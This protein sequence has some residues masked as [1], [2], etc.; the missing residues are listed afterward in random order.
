MHTL[1]LFSALCL[2]AAGGGIGTTPPPPPNPSFANTVLV[3]GAATLPNGSYSLVFSLI[4]NFGAQFFS[5]TIFQE[6]QQVTVTGSRFSTRLGSNTGGG[7]PSSLLAGRA[8]LGVSWALATSPTVS[9]G[10]LSLPGL[11]TALTLAPQATVAGRSSVTPALTVSGSSKG[12]V[13]TSSSTSGRGLIGDATSTLGL[14]IG[15][16]G[17][18]AA[19]AGAGG[20]FLNSGAGGDVLHARNADGASPVFRVT[21]SGDV[22]SAG[23]LVPQ[24]GPNGPRGDPG[25]PAAKGPTG[26]K[27]PKGDRFA[28]GTVQG[29]CVVTKA[30]QCQGACQMS[31]KLVASAQATNTQSCYA[32][33]ATGTC[34]T[35][36]TGSWC[37]SCQ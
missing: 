19:P 20:S 29:Y 16:E 11:A 35:G 37:C 24:Y 18:S 23:A 30:N 8:R 15:V 36:D 17:T 22:I 28:A 27:G 26:P 9:L 31:M 12:L 33:S 21:A 1:L 6:A 32:K 4:D 13:G 3:E 10:S 2:S 14:A 5:P 34:T 25:D 7:I